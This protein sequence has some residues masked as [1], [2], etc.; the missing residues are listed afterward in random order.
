MATLAKMVPEGPGG[1]H[2]P[3]EIVRDRIRTAAGRGYRIV[4][5]NRKRKASALRIDPTNW[6][7]RESGRI[8]TVLSNAAEEAYRLERAGYSSAFFAVTINVCAMWP[9]LERRT[10]AELEEMLRRELREENRTNGAANEQEDAW[11]DGEN[12]C[13]ALREAHLKQAARSTRICALLDAIEHKRE[14]AD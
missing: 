14:M 12:V 4:Q 1:T 7:R 3:R 8:N 6:S 2:A 5:G 10:V 11:K 13:E 9:E